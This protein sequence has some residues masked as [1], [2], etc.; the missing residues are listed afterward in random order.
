MLLLFYDDLSFAL[1]TRSR[2]HYAKRPRKL[3]GEGERAEHHDDHVAEQKLVLRGHLHGCRVHLHPGGNVRVLGSRQ[4]EHSN[5]L[6]DR[7]CA[8]G[9]IRR[10]AAAQVRHVSARRHQRHLDPER[11]VCHPVDLGGIF[12]L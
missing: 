10:E 3:I 2:G 7:I 8:S 11:Q 6:R 5:A 12:V 9:D 4:T 1:H